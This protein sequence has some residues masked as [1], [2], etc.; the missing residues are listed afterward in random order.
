MRVDFPDGHWAEI[1]T[2]SEMPRRIT[3]RM[4]EMLAE[5]PDDQNGY[6]YGRD[7]GRLRDTMLAMV[8]K[9]WSYD[10]QAP[11]D[12]ANDVYDLPQASYDKLREET[13]EHWK[14]AGF[15]EADSTET[16]ETPTETTAEKTPESSTFSA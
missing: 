13:R 2:V 4:Q 1:Y 14:K 8:T 12:S 3:V 7:M 6:A 9:Q 11:G 15:F 5:I 10:G 16:E